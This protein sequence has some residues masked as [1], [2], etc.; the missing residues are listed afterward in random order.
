M[1]AASR[2][3]TSGASPCSLLSKVQH[4]DLE[5]NSWW[6]RR[7]KLESQ[8]AHL[9]QQ[10]LEEARGAAILSTARAAQHVLGEQ[11]TCSVCCAACVGQARSLKSMHVTELSVRFTQCTAGTAATAGPMLAVPSEDRYAA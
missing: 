2:L 10:A 1:L 5:R 6:R 3:T 9:G 7:G 4:L 8:R 11:V